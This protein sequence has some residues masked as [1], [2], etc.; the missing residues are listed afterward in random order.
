MLKF[1]QS[2]SRWLSNYTS[3][4]IIGIAVVTFF[5]P[6]LFDWVRGKTQTVILG[7]IMLTMGLTLST[8][9]FKVLAK[10]PLDIF[11][12]ACA[13]FIIM[14]GIAYLLVRVWRLEPALALGIL[15]VGCCPGGVSSNVMSFLCRGDVAFSVGMT[16]ASTILA[17]F[18][19]P[20]LMKL[21]A[22]EII[23]I[24]AVR[25]FMDIF[26]VTIFPIAIGCML[27]YFYSKRDVFPKIQSFMPG[28]SVICLA[29]IV[30]GVISTVHDKLVAR[31]FYLF[32]WTFAVVFCHNTLG[33][34]MGYLSGKFAGFS[35]A[36][37]RTIS[38]EVGMQNAGLATV[39]AG[40]F[41]AAQPLAVLPCAISCAWHS[42]SG[43]IL[44]GLYLKWDQTHDHQ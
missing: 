14:P 18:M 27:N 41:F 11:V 26:I 4:F 9:D 32:I 16:C 40:N 13:Q 35:I 44:A 5:F 33:Y 8:N 15:L 12:G 43:T 34:I 29:F 31:G 21:T 10:R 20:F 38:I 36:K 30:G 7:I 3:A 17:P 37:K 39:L 25:M 42:I 23:I 24:D 22:G 1:L 2:I 6:H 28:V 19:T